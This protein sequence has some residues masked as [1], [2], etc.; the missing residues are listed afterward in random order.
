MISSVAFSC[1]V[2]ACHKVLTKRGYGHPT[3]PALTALRLIPTTARLG[4]LSSFTSSTKTTYGT[5]R[6]D[7]TARL[8]CLSE[9]SMSWLNACPTVALRLRLQASEY[10][11][12]HKFLLGRAAASTEPD[13]DM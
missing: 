3:K 9:H 10:T 11:V 1:F 13:T 8:A 5:S 6:L 2:T 4:G 7:A 12:L